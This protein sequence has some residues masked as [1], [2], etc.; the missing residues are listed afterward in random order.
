MLPGGASLL[1][2]RAIVRNYL[3]DTFEW[4]VNLVL[5]G[6]QVPSAVLGESA[7]LGHTCWMG[8]RDNSRDADE[9]HL[10]A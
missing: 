1:R 3:G 4:D 9:L 7:V 2:L 8:E 6:D 5:R 10:V